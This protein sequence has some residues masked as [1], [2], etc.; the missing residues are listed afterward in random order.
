[1]CGVVLLDGAYDWC[2]FLETLMS[3]LRAR[4]PHAGYKATPN[5]LDIECHLLES[6]CPTIITAI[7]GAVDPDANLTGNT[8]STE[9]TT[10]ASSSESP[11]PSESPP[12]GIG[13]GEP[14]LMLY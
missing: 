7:E 10:S 4:C 8:T 11:N 1:M 14:I 13:L 5:Y 9:D 2:H 3:S 6:H 12:C